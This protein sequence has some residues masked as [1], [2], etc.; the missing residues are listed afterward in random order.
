MKAFSIWKPG[1]FLQQSTHQGFR[2][3][4]C[5]S[6]GLAWSLY[7]FGTCYGYT[8]DRGSSQTAEAC[9]DFYIEH[10]PAD[11]VPPWDF[12]A[13]AG[14][15]Q[16]GGYVGGGD[17]GQR[18]VPS[19]RGYAPI[20]S[21]ATLRSDGAAMLARSAASIWAIHARMGRHSEGRR[22]SHPEKLGVDE[23]VMWGEYFFLEALDA[24]LGA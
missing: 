2:G 7:G 21:R 1:E 15:P 13:P 14:E 24:V 3:D 9:A 23:S 12:D 11:G 4:S 18:P 17:R 5:W 10:T 6:R 22:L 20:R 19:W 8:R 16:A